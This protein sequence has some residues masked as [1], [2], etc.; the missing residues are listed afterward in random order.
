MHMTL[1][2]EEVLLL[3]F[4]HSRYSFYPRK[5]ERETNDRIIKFCLVP[6]RILFNPTDSVVVAQV[7]I[8]S[9][10]YLNKS[11]EI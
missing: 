5:T 9:E 2:N 3:F 1:R 10:S 4:S 6:A 7:E 11:C 8:S